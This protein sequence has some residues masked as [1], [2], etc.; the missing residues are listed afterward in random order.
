MS[1]LPEKGKKKAFKSG[2]LN[3]GVF[4]DSTGVA[5]YQQ[6]TMARVPA[7]Q[8]RAVMLSLSC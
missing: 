7:V 4:S 1:I 8:R 2:D 3:H 6:P 5:E